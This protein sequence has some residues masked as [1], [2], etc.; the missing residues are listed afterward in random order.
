MAKRKPPKTIPKAAA[1]APPDG[2]EQQLIA[3]LQRIEAL[4]ARPGLSLIH[5]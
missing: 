4:F 1:G 3:K 2:P 5:I